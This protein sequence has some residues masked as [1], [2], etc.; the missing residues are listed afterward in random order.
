[1]AKGA[2]IGTEK[3]ITVT[4][5]LDYNTLSNN[6]GGYWGKWNL[7]GQTDYVNWG[8]GSYPPGGQ[9]SG[10]F[11]KN[12]TSG[13]AEATYQL[14]VQSGS[15]K[16]NLNSSHL[17]YFSIYLYQPSIVGSFACYWPIA[18]PPAVSNFTV[19]QINTWERH[20]AI[21][22]RN[23][24][25][26][27]SY[28]VRFDFDNPTS[29]STLYFGNVALVDLTATFGAGFEPDKEW[30]DENINF[31]DSS[32]TLASETATIT[33]NYSV[34]RKV[35][36][37]YVGID[38]IAHKVIKGYIGVGGVARPFFAPG[39]E[40]YGQINSLS[41]AR[42]PLGVS[43]LNNQ[44]AVFSNQASFSGSGSLQ[45]GSK[46]VDIY[47]TSLTHSVV[48]NIVGRA[49]AGGGVTSDYVIYAGGNNDIE[50]TSTITYCNS[51]FTFSQKST[52]LSNEG[53]DFACT[54]F[55]NYVFLAGGLWKTEDNSGALNKIITISN[56]LSVSSRYTMPTQ[57]FGMGA[58]ASNNYALM[59]GGRSYT[60]GY[61]DAV[62]GYNTS[63]SRI[64]VPDLS[65]ARESLVG[66]CV[67]DN[68]LFCGGSTGSDSLSNV[69]D[70]YSSS[71]TKI[72]MSNL[73]QSL[74]YMSYSPLS[75]SGIFFGGDNSTDNYSNIAYV[76]DE[77]LTLNVLT[78]D[79]GV[80][81]AG[82]AS[83]N[84]YALFAGGRSSDGN[85]DIVQ[86]FVIN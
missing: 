56:S 70:A 27:G 15:I 42:L 57:V 31:L 38:N 52:G 36:K 45:S 82:G 24:F 81:G 32:S 33:V 8:S 6:N 17:Y 5:L 29:N 11:D 73:P 3:I 19:S 41:K 46:N 35:K 65:T 53:Y 59:G 9:R 79:I 85:T 67:G 1:M 7:S 10:R 84:N 77:S 25:S 78:A 66:G 51:S 60:S 43:F 28:E 72:T 13:L 75:T 76:Y 48:E 37:M 69:V 74:Q 12:I 18:E 54:S 62:Y 83:V 80:Y 50:S 44:Y 16:I 58:A 34:A 30:C 4:N 71:L 61:Q 22:N 40:Y 63:M 14:T 39:A 47:N 55:N 21:F 68:I 49:D 26:N 23:S 86:A 2:Y 64:T 20:S